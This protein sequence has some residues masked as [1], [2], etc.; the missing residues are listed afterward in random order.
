MWLRVEVVDD[1]KWWESDVVRKKKKRGGGEVEVGGYKYEG[2]EGELI[3][4]SSSAFGFQRG[5]SRR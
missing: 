4:K 3:W 1:K 2:W 5:V